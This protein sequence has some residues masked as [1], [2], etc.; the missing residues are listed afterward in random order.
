M[1]DAPP[2]REDGR[3][4]V[5]LGP[6]VVIPKVLVKRSAHDLRVALE[7]DAFCSSSC[8]RAYYGTS[9]PAVSTGNRTARPIAPIMHGTERGYSRG[10]RCED[11]RNAA[12]K[13][14]RER[15]QTA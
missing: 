6:R 12:T 14:R 8:A 4:V 11:C 2:V 7:A 9:L 10:C 3:C 13:N 5:C 1:K 15:R